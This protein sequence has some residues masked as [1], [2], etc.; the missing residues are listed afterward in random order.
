[1]N[2]RHLWSMA[3]LTAVAV[4]GAP[5]LAVMSPVKF[6]SISTGV[7]VRAHATALSNSDNQEDDGSMSAEAHA[8]ASGFQTIYQDPD[9][10]VE[11]HCDADS[12]VSASLEEVWS[13]DP[14]AT[15]VILPGYLV[16]VSGS[17]VVM[18]EQ[19]ATGFANAEAHISISG[20]FTV[21]AIPG[22]PEGTLV[23]VFSG[24]MSGDAMTGW[25]LTL[26]DP[27]NNNAVLGDTLN[28]DHTW[29]VLSLAP[30]QQV[31]FQ[32][33]LDNFNVQGDSSMI[34]RVP[35]PSMLVFAGLGLLLSFPRRRR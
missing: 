13:D 35:E 12:M 14:I 1:M 30:G 23:D 18:S 11:V 24:A 21:N 5:A 26:R 31:A 33:N 10:P 17:S 9:P 6:E 7:Q 22:E 16:T 4:Y 34:I 32:F 15:G 8:H 25:S 20:T 28:P 2:R 27:A 29:Q 19:P 3:V